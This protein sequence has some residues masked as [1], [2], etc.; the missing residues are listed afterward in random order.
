MIIK[1]IYSHSSFSAQPSKSGV[2]FTLTSLFGPR[3]LQVVNSHMYLMATV[4]VV[5]EQVVAPGG[6]WLREKEVQDS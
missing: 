5:Q 6:D 1:E 2:Y 4:W 3:T